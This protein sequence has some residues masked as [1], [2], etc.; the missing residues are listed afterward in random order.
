MLERQRCKTVEMKVREFV[1]V[2][3]GGERSA[4]VLPA[5]RVEGESKWWDI[6]PRGPTICST[7]IV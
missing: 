6:F 7:P 1:W 3:T 2:L 5:I 4:G